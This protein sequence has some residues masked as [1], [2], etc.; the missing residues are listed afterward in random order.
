[1]ISK[2]SISI[3]KTNPKLY[4]QIHEWAYK[5]VPKSELCNRCSQRKKLEASNNSGMYAPHVDD[6]EWICKHCHALKDGWG[7]NLIKARQVVNDNIKKRKP[8][9]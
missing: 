1:M 3:R 2:P 4:S 5:N 8:L 7:R 9:F 6:W